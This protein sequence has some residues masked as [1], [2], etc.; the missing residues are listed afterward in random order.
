[1][2]GQGAGRRQCVSW[3]SS[4]LVSFHFISQHAFSSLFFLFSISPT[5]YYNKKSSRLAGAL[6]IPISFARTCS[7][8]MKRWR[9]A[10]LSDR[11]Y[12][13]ALRIR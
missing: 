5:R 9:S 3:I 11:N 1:M 12:I 7:K 8:E 6:W 2:S 13:H 10:W 4:H